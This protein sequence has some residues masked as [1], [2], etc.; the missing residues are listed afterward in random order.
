MNP[1]DF[2]GCTFIGHIKAPN[3]NGGKPVPLFVP[4]P[5]SGNMSINTLEGW[6]ASA[7]KQNR[8]SFIKPMDVTPQTIMRFGGGSAL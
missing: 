4:C 6:N 1:F 7:D 8:R 2:P 5:P 3:V